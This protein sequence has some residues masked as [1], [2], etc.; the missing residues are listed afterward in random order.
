MLNVL[1]PA[2]ALAMLRPFSAALAL[3]QVIE[4]ES[5]IVNIRDADGRLGPLILTLVGLGGLTIV[6]T[7]LFWWLTRPQQLGE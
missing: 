2:L 5:E 6:G 3:G 1:P 4:G 7:V